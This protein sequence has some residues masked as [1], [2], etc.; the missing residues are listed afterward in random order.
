MAAPK[1]GTR[2]QHSPASRP[3]EVLACATLRFAGDS[4]DGMR[5]AGAQFT[6][7]AA[8]SGNDVFTVPEHP[9]EIRAPDGSLAGVSGLLVH[10]GGT[11]GQ[12]PG[13]HLDALVAMN[14]A[15]LRLHLPELGPGGILIVNRDAIHAAELAKAG[16]STDPL[17]DGSLAPYR[18]VAAPITTLNRKALEQDRLSPRDADR[19][20]NF[21]ALGLTYCLYGLPLEP[22]LRWLDAKYGAPNPAARDASGRSLRAGYHYGETVAELPARYHV[23]PAPTPPGLYR[24]VSGNEAVAL[25]LVAAASAAG[26]SLVY[27]AHPMTPASELLHRLAGL[28]HFG[29]RTVQAEDEAAAAGAALGAAFGGALGVTAT[30]GPGMGP[31]S[32]GVG[33]AVMTELPLVVLDVQRGGPSTGLATKTEQADLLQSLFGRNGES[34]AV[35]LAPASPADCFRMAY[36]AVRLAVGFMTP[37]ILLTDA[38]LAGAAEVWRVPDPD[39]LVPIPVARAAAPA[40]GGPP[41]LPYKRDA[42]LVRDWAVPGTPGLEHRVGGLEKEDGTGNVSYDPDNH[43]HMV[44]KRAA[45]VAGVAATIPE[46]EVDGPASGDLLVVGWGSTHGA[47]AGAAARARQAGASVAHAH[48]RYLNP[49]PRNTGAVLRRYHKVLVAELNGGQFLLMLRAAFL[50]DAVGLNKIQGQPFRVGEVEAK[51]R[52]ML[53]R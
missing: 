42:R 30:S 53:E 20:K 28:A 32:E 11:P 50:V 35:V 10:F 46:L 19:R 26:L 13:D 1:P 38:H 4:G 9:A 16:Y 44:R 23:R 21:F 47:L 17:A 43:E 31:K 25:G 27:A 3:V 41:F 2:P 22:T 14:P 8:L 7:T 45:K 36:E 24:R 49:L 6:Q 15:A 40:A 37:V 29:V 18:V 48:F 52:Q 33:L 39:V 5:L 12:A 51:I 34:P